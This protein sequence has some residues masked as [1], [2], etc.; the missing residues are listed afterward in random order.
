[1]NSLVL[2]KEPRALAGLAKLETYMD[3]YLAASGFADDKD[4][5]LWR[6]TGRKTGNPSHLTPIS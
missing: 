1:M 6:T 4:G 5:P 3:E 2:F